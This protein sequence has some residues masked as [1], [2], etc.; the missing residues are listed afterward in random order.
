MKTSALHM[1]PLTTLKGIGPKMA[2]KLERLG[3]R[4]IQDM[5]FHLPAKYQDRT[6]LSAVASLRPGDYAT[7]VVEAVNTRVHM[8]RKRSLLIKVTDQ[9]GVLTLRFFRF[10]AAMQQQ[11]A[12]GQRI[13]VYGEVRPGPTGPEMIHP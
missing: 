8:G 5:L 6:K 2:E 10:S 4:T 9:T 1:I 11:F 3:L 13:Q 12:V 7:L